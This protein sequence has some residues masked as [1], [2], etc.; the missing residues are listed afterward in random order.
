MDTGGIGDLKGP[1][2]GQKIKWDIPLLN[3]YNYTFLKNYS[4]SKSLSNNFFDAINF[5]VITE[6][7]K[8]KSDILIINGWSYFSNILVLKFP[9]P[10]TRC[11]I[12]IYLYQIFYI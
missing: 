10:S 3:G 11:I 2:N 8:S 6:I 4:N 1:K 5:K 12:Y 7:A 9:N